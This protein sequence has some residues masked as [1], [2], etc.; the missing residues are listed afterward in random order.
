MN[1]IINKMFGLDIN[2]INIACYEFVHYWCFDILD[3]IIC[4]IYQA[5]IWNEF[6]PLSKLKYLI[7]LN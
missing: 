2:I 7:A 3:I 6:L 1:I 4:T 5:D